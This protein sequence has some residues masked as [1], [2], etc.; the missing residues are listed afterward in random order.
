MRSNV[1]PLFPDQEAPQEAK[2]AESRFAE[3]WSIY[4]KRVG[5]PL[6][7]AKFDAIVKGGFKTRTLDRDSGQ[8][9]EIEI[10]ATADEIIAGTRRYVESLIDKNTFKRKIEDKFI[11]HPATFLNQGRWADE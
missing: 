10:E 4:P 1:A 11:P 8:F 7:K 6:A 5:K 9:V 2:K 3:F